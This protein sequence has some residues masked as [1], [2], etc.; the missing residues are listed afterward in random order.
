MNQIFEK[1]K[2]NFFPYRNIA[3]YLYFLELYVTITRPEGRVSGFQGHIQINRHFLNYSTIH[4]SS[5][6]ST[7][8][9]YYLKETFRMSKYLRRTDRIPYTSDSG[10]LCLGVYFWILIMYCDNIN[11][12]YKNFDR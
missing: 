2:A 10:L 5:F 3:P 4:S 6:T 9:N 1:E 11:D 7:S 12:L 8:K